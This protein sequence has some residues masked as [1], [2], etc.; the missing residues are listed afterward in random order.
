M[1]FEP[2]EFPEGEVPKPR[3]LFVHGDYGDKVFFKDD[4]YPGKTFIYASTPSYDRR[5]R[6]RRP[7]QKAEA[8]GEAEA[9]IQG[10]SDSRQHT[11]EADTTKK[12]VTEVQDTSDPQQFPDGVVPIPSKLFVDGKLWDEVLF[13]DDRYPGK[14][15]IYTSGFAHD[16][17]TLQSPSSQESSTAERCNTGKEDANIQEIS[18]PE[19]FP[20]GVVPIPG[21][22]FVDGNFRDKV[23][24]RDNRYPGKRFIYTSNLQH[25]RRTQYS[26][27]TERTGPVV[28]GSDEDTEDETN[29]QHDD[30]KT[31]HAA[32][33]SHDPTTARANG[34]ITS[35]ESP[36][37]FEVVC[38]FESQEETL[39]DEAPAK[40]TEEETVTDLDGGANNDK[41]I[42]EDDAISHKSDTASGAES[43]REAI[44]SND[45]EEVL[46]QDQQS[47]TEPPQVGPFSAQDAVSFQKA[48]ASAGTISEE[49]CDPDAALKEVMLPS[50]E[51]PEGTS[52]DSWDLYD[53][54]RIMQK[55]REERYQELQ[56]AIA[57]GNERLGL[58][59]VKNLI[60]V[61]L[62]S[63]VNDNQ[64]DR[65]PT[66]EKIDLGV[67]D[68]SPGTRW[69]VLEMQ[70]IRKE[71]H[72]EKQRLQEAIDSGI[73]VPVVDDIKG[74]H[75]DVPGEAVSGV[76]SEVVFADPLIENIVVVDS[77][78]QQ[79]PA[80]PTD[81][82]PG[83]CGDS[84]AWKESRGILG[85]ELPE[86][87]TIC[88]GLTGLII[89]FLFFRPDMFPN[90]I[91]RN[92]RRFVSPENLSIWRWTRL[93]LGLLIFF[94][95]AIWGL[96]EGLFDVRCDVAEKPDRWPQI[97]Y[98]PDSAAP[99][100]APKDS[101]AQRERRW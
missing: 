41:A 38:V 17:R 14:T 34:K 21:D 2:E 52:E 61:D 80:L 32:E 13:T 55:A 88:Q 97:W 63:Q 72:Q 20:T 12:V 11:L 64:A 71:Y 35:D 16:R 59:D 36:G 93:L 74:L 33:P 67:T 25:D 43:R 31:D 70:R 98:Y 37:D 3:E 58:K 53:I 50:M 18:E 51:H 100:F 24:F 96:P 89:L 91:K 23:L 84:L 4:R 5:A 75:D 54:W 57:S 83:Q 6:R 30:T 79:P 92:C 90:I 48:I 65:K 9:E 85:G 40:P 42:N 19:N 82:H 26:R 66:A 77:N 10:V 8:T 94:G 62:A 81:C 99:I 27:S 22:L 69:S 101:N 46:V 28:S 87:E 95:I 44:D 76:A 39:A 47:A 1:I 15:F 78:T 45:V 86:C 56:D 29:V 49:N 60:E 7:A 68:W 73:E